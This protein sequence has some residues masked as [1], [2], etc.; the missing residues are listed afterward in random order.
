MGIKN[1]LNCAFFFFFFGIPINLVIYII[2]DYYFR[3]NNPLLFPILF[4]IEFI[5]GFLV[6]NDFGEYR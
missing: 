2:L 5:I 1:R 3:V 4:V 6:G